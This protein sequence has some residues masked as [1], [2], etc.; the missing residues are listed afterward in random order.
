MR[1]ARLTF[2]P[3]YICFATPAARAAVHTVC[4]FR[5]C[6]AFCAAAAAPLPPRYA[7]FRFPSIFFVVVACRRRAH[8]WRATLLVVHYCCC[9]F[10]PPAIYLSY[11]PGADG[12]I[13]YGMQRTALPHRCRCALNNAFLAAAYEPAAVMAAIPA[14]VCVT[15]P[16]WRCR[17]G[18]RCV[19]VW[20]ARFGATLR[21]LLRARRDGW[22]IFARALPRVPFCRS[23][24]ACRC[25]LFNA[26][27]HSA[28]RALRFKP[29]RNAPRITFRAP[30]RSRARRYAY[31]LPPLHTYAYLC[32]PPPARTACPAFSAPR[33]L[34][35]PFPATTIG[36]FG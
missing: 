35:F 28:P 20:N 13:I 27:Q 11:L 36:L 2:V 15:T 23:C 24:A 7:H 33:V 1:T 14:T 21:P 5:P 29:Y 30:P 3:T 31:R 18:C 26:P 22:R 9:S 19:T 8:C 34:R 6:L 25:F 4:L 17:C 32:L 10:L 12:Y 16:L